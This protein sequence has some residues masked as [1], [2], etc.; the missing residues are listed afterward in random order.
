[1]FV[2][3]LSRPDSEVFVPSMLSNHDIIVSEPEIDVSHQLIILAALA[4]Q[5][6][7]LSLL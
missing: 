6:L 7:V 1:M 2:R 5:I 4:K 3:P